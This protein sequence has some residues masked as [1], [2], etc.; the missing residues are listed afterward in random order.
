MVTVRQML[1][2]SKAK[3]RDSAD[4]E[5]LEISVPHYDR[6]QKKLSVSAVVKSSK[7]TGYNVRVAFFDVEDQGMKPEELAAGNFPIPDDIMNKPIKVD[8]DCMDYT[9]GGALKGN[10]KHGSAL[11]TDAQLTNYK[12]KTDR[13]ENNPENLPYGCKHITSVLKTVIDILKSTK[14]ITNQMNNND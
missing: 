11:Y 10:L 1:D 5:I 4:V 14:N 9:L 7:G 12:K 6:A 2:N 3:K 13:P 8:C